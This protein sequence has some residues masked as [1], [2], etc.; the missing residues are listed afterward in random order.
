MPRLRQK[1]HAP[2]P[3]RYTFPS[4]ADQLDDH[5]LSAAAWLLVDEATASTNPLARLLLLEA[6]VGMLATLRDR[7]RT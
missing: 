5:E 1:I 3:A 4:F 7:A 2:E 6:S